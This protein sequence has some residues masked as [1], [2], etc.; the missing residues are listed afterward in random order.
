MGALQTPPTGVIHV[1]AFI[2]L[3]TCLSVFFRWITLWGLWRRG[4]RRPT[5]IPIVIFV[6]DRDEYIEGLLRQLL[7]V[8]TSGMHP[9]FKWE[10]IVIDDGSSDDTR[11]ILTRLSREYPILKPLFKEDINALH[12]NVPPVSAPITISIDLLQPV[13]INELQATIDRLFQLA[14]VNPPLIYRFIATRSPAQLCRPN[15]EGPVSVD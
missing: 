3:V 8:V 7:P 15:R 5:S 12:G 2:G 11:Q 10:L 14:F 9:G 1:L 4:L 13:D 6:R